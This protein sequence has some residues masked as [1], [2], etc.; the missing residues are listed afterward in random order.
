MLHV[1]QL[2]LRAPW[3]ELKRVVWLLPDKVLG[4]V[5][6]VPELVPEPELVICHQLV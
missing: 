2:E 3:L 1:L 4:F 6:S 5:P